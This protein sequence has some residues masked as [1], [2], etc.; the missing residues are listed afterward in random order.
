MKT[1]NILIIFLILNL[2]LPNLCFAQLQL[3][4]DMEGVEGMREEAL[5][6]G[7]EKMPEM[8][9]NIYREDVLPVWRKMYEWFESHIWIKVKEVFGEEIEKRKP[10]IEQEFEKEKGGIKEELLDKSLW[11]RFRDL[12]R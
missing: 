8:I 1:K 2:V 10:I 11:G 7:K 12:V 4:E 3:P 9:K 5:D 6:I